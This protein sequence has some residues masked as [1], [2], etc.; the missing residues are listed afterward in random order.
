LKQGVSVRFLQLDIA[1]AHAT[2]EL[3]GALAL[4]GQIQPRG[5]RIMT[6]VM[7]KT[8]GGWEIVALQSSE[9]VP[10]PSA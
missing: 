10:P 9:V 4:D 3:I 2:W 5:P 6:K 1:V 7:R 8:D